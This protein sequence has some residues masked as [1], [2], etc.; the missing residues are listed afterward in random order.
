MWV[1]E[2][3]LARRRLVSWPLHNTPP[4]S[5]QLGAAPPSQQRALHHI[6]GYC[7]PTA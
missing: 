6:V 5:Q 1:G 3:S 7:T 2:W 4:H